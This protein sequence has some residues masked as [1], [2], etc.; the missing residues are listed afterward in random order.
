MTEQSTSNSFIVRIY[1]FDTE[2][3][4][5]LTGLVEAMDGSGRRES[6]ANM[7]ELSA[8]LNRAVNKPRGRRKKVA[9]AGDPA[10]PG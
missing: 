7:D 4:R 5:R 1:R 3:P 6:F 10:V 8:I 9:G 2:D